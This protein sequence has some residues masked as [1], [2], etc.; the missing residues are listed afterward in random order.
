MR[1]KDREYIFFAIV[2]QQGSQEQL[3]EAAVN[4]GTPGNSLTCASPKLQEVQ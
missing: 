1:K 3:K 2:D 4:H